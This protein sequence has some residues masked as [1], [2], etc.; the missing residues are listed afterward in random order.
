MKKILLAL[1][2]V[3]TMMSVQAETG[4]LSL[5]GQFNYGTKRSMIGLGVQ[6]QYEPVTNFRFAPEF[7][8]YF[9]SDDVSAIN[10][11]FNMHYLIRTSTSSAVYP[12]AGFSYAHYSWDNFLGYDDEDK[13]GANLGI[14]FEYALAR[15]FSLYTEERFQILGNHYNQVV[16][17]LGIKYNF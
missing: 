4:D 17:A 11:N 3:M 7:I 9:E 16:T 6:L 14:G 2:A 13:F 1:V 12:I 5:G 15:N 8:Y 10:A